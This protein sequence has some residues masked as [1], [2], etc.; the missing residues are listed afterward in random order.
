MSFYQYTDCPKCKST[1]KYP[2]SA[3]LIRCP[4]CKYISNPTAPQQLPCISC[5]TLLAFPPH[6]QYIRCPKCRVI[7]RIRDN[8][9]R[10]ELLSFKNTP[11]D[12]NIHY[13]P[14]PSNAPMGPLFNP[15]ND[16]NDNTLNDANT[17][18]TETTNSSTNSSSGSTSKSNSNSTTDS[19]MSDIQL[20]PQST[21]L[22]QSLTN[23]R[24]RNLRNFLIQQQCLVFF[25]SFISPLVFLDKH[26]CTLY[27]ASL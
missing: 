21:S 16:D 19:E 23:I 24:R 20:Q 2:I 27:G 22:I 25:C 13:T 3:A 11:T 5:H 8:P 26:P 18:E 9:N 14:F 10:N 7:I 12:H 4:A 6:S 17:T 1:L 15:L